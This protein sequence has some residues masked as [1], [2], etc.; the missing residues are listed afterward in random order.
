MKLRIQFAGWL[1]A[2]GI[3]VAMALPSAAQKHD[4]NKPPQQQR[5]QQRQTQQQR[6]PQRQERGQARPEARRPPNGGDADPP[7]NNAPPDKPTETMRTLR[8][9]GRPPKP[10]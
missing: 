7:P 6:Q 10:G 4:A 3:S 5:Q 8:G 9:G 2:L 1:I